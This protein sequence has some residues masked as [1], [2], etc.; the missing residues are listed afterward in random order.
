MRSASATRPTCLSNSSAPLN[1]LNYS[2]CTGANPVSVVC[3]GIGL[4]LRERR[5][6]AQNRLNLADILRPTSEVVTRRC[7]RSADITTLLVPPTQRIISLRRPSVSG[8]YGASVE[9][10]AAMGPPHHCCHFAG[11]RKLISF[12]SRIGLQ[13]TQCTISF[14][15][16]TTL[17]F[18]LV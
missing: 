1:L 9:Q 5:G 6:T 10:S 7:L 2:T 16:F 14:Q 8:G 17:F 11:R 18:Y 12:V 3:S 4:S 15:L 13:L